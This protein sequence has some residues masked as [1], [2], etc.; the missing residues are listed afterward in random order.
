[1][2]IKKVLQTDLKDCGVSCLMS[3]I[4]Y[5]GGYAR[6]EYLREITKTTISGV[7]VYSLVCCATNLGFE[8]KA[9]KGNIL[10]IKSQVPFIAHVMKDNKLGH[11]VVVCNVSDKIKVMDPSCG[12]KTYSMKEWEKITTNVYI[13]YKPINNILKQDKEYSFIKIILPIFY[14]YKITFLIILMFSLIYICSSIFISYGFNLFMSLNIY[15]IKYILI[16]LILVLLLKELTNLFRNNLINYL[17]HSLDNSLINEI[18]NHIIR[19]PYLFFKNRTKGDIITRINDIFKIRDLISKLFV[20]IC[21]DLI[22][23]I[24][25]LNIIYSINIKIGIIISVITI[26]YILI[27]IIYNHF[28]TNKIIVI[29]EKEKLVN[30]HLIESISS[31]DTVKGMVIEEMLANKLN[32]K[33]YDLQRLSFSLNKN[34]YNK[35]FFKEI[36]QGTLMILIIYISVI[37]V[38]NNRL[39]IGLV[40]VIYNLFTYYFE[41]IN[42][43]CSIE[44]DYKDAKISFIRIKELL[45]ISCE[46]LN[47]D[48]KV[49]NK[50]L[51]GNIKVNNLIYSYN[52]IDDVLNCKSL[53]INSSNKV[54]FYGESGGGKST[55]MKLITRYIS[56]Y[57]GDILL[58]DR[59]LSTYN[60]LDIRN[61]ITYV[62]Q[63]EII[64][65]DTIYNNIVLNHDIK[66]SKYLEIVKLCEIDKITKRSIL[67]DEMLLENNGLNLS[68]GER[69]RII[70]ARSLIKNS[71]IYIFDESFNSL[72]IKSER[73]LLVKLF[74]Y[75]KNKTVIVISH[76]FNNRDLYQK[77]IMI[78]KGI[79]YEY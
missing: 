23:V 54:L 64:Y 28:I 5:Y 61:K 41:P 68:L 55:L 63:D 58:D 15:K 46:R 6:R 47:I 76:R 14:K 40:I 24:V 9:L 18:Y 45:N 66:Y 25:I 69:Q 62:S 44:L 27:I 72:D 43:M 49:I 48:S 34:I 26:I 60:L 30:N 36:L 22:F 56:K 74:K 59:E 52:G 70:I 65:T 67:G 53:T 13:L 51:Y 16:L 37:E 31:I 79:V 10:N 2:K 29:K 19:L 42:N 8:A 78:K 20:S 73:V 71:D 35:N 39:N 32:N 1:M 57:K 50:H 75:L 12:F 38:L 17:N 3:I 77:F 4:N 11:F 21:I 7:S 33:Y